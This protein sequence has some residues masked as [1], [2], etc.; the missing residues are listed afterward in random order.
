MNKEL[1]LSFF[2]ACVI[3]SINPPTMELSEC[4]CSERQSLVDGE[5]GSETEVQ[6]HD[7]GHNNC[8][9][10]FPSCPGP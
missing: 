7:A 8:W 6:S 5:D 4:L 9:K 10:T 1:G 3:D 2:S